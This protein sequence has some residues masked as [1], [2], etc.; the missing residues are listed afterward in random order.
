MSLERW[1]RAAPFIRG[2][3]ITLGALFL[4]TAMGLRARTISLGS[5]DRNLE[6]VRRLPVA[7]PVKPTASVE[8]APASPNLEQ[9]CT[10]RPNR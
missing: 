6:N 7:E 9:A 5:A 2:G 8:C 1:G 4:I 10:E 3:V